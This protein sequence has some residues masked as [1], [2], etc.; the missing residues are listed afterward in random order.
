[1]AKE[2]DLDFILSAS[3]EDIKNVAEWKAQE[4]IQEGK[5]A[6]LHE[7]LDCKSLA[8]YY[9]EMANAYKEEAIVEWEEYG[10]KEITVRGKKITKVESGIKYNYI[11]CNYPGYEEAVKNLKDI[12]KEL[13]KAKSPFDLVDEDTGEEITVRPAVRTSTTTLKLE[14]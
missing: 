14:Y 1:M 4:V 12:E 13:R 6:I 11:K 5:T 9:T 2:D 10:E 7:F 3:K 8:L